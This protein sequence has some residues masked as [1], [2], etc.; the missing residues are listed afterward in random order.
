VREIER[1]LVE[2]AAKLPRASELSAIS[3]KASA[4]G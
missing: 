4:C 1:L 2:Q 3:R